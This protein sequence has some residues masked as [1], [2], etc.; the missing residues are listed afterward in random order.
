MASVCAQDIQVPAYRKPE[1]QQLFASISGYTAKSDGVP[2]FLSQLNQCGVKFIVLPHLEKTYLDGAAFIQ[3][4]NPVLVYTAR[5]NR[6]DNF[7]FTIAHEIAHV[8]LHLSK[9]GDVILDDLD[10][11]ENTDLE[12]EANAAAAEQL[13]HKEIGACF[14]CSGQ[15]HPKRVLACARMY[16]LHPSIVAGKLA[17]E[18]AIG[19]R[20]IQRFNEE[21]VKVIPKKFVF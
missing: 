7:W 15:V 4:E 21:V 8:L 19:Y 3:E 10:E 12:Q 13:K 5:Y 17:R 14:K 18:G 6:V 1:L 2:S 16:N 9:S 11:R 20:L